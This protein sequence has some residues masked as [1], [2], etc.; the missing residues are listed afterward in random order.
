METGQSLH[1]DMSEVER[2]RPLIDAFRAEIAASVKDQIETVART[3]A[4]AGQQATKRHLE[5]LGVAGSLVQ[6]V[7]ESRLLIEKYGFEISNLVQHLTSSIQ[8]IACAV[9]ENRLLIDKYGF[10]VN[11][12]VQHLTSSIQTTA[13]AVAESRLLIDKYGFEVDNRV[14][15]LTTS[16]LARLNEVEY[17]ALRQVHETIAAELG[18]RPGPDASHAVRP[19]GAYRPAEATPFEAVM[20]RAAADFPKVF[21]PWHERLVRTSEAFDRTMEGNAANELDLYSRAFSGFVRAYVEG[22][23]LDV[24]P[25]VFGR[26]YYLR[27]HPRELI[28]GI[29]PLSMKTP[30][31]FEL[32]HGIGEYLPWPDGSFE[33]VISATSIDHC[34]SL[35][36]SLQEIARVLNPRGRV[37][38]WV[39]AVV[40]ASVFNP[41]ADSFAPAD[42]YHLFHVDTAWFEPRLLEL[43]EIAERVAMDHVSH[44]HVFYCLRRR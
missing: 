16:V 35:D 17:R 3:T 7:A 25:G 21:A 38:L 15:H 18:Q 42:Q 34:L 30:P 43:F 40:G 41:D 13:S 14:Q 29:E 5:I 2:V 31:D 11:N 6:A 27:H 9:A 19:T 33:T 12:R 39:G 24:G 37:L 22:R 20:D 8:T 1:P 44:A 32:V 23:V 26:P 4:D 36:R 10:E 28:S